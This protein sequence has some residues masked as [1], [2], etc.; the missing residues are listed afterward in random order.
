M[1]WL[2]LISLTVACWY[3]ALKTPTTPYLRDWRLKPFHL[4]PEE[5]QDF[6]KSVRKTLALTGAIFFSVCILI[7]LVAFVRALVGYGS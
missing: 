5:E 7:A 4:A 3:F 6:H 2:V 1:F